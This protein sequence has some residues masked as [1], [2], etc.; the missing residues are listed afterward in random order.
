M[1]HHPSASLFP[2]LDDKSL[3]DLAEDIHKNGL[4]E[5]IVVHEGMILDGRNRFVACELAGVPPAFTEW[6]NGVSPTV[7][8]L[9]KNLH[10]RHLTTSQRAAIAVEVLPLLKEEAHRRQLVGKKPGLPLNSEGGT[11]HV[12]EARQIAARELR[13]GHATVWEAE[14]VKEKDPAMFEKVR[15]G[16]ATV[17]GAY[18]KATGRVRPENELQK[19]PIAQREKQIRERAEEGYRATQIADE[20]GIGVERVRELARRLG[21][22]IRADEIRQNRKID[23][24]RIVGETVAS[25][26]ALVA[27]LD[28]V[29]ARLDQIDQLQ[30]QPWIASLSDSISILK[31][32]LNKLRRASV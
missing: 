2:M 30:L 3:Q 11:P 18:R 23:V 14:Q 27:G 9:S 8:V 6:N 16:E 4:L 31:G 29:D 19:L 26:Q 21:I 24:N 1:Q 25:A 28:L 10:R 12:G 13:V 22:N 20:L 15:R 32:L 5:P 7:Y 17:H